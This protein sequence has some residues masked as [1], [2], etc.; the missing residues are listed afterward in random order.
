MKDCVDFGWYLSMNLINLH[1]F[2]LWLHL[3]HREQLNNLP[4]GNASSCS[5]GEAELSVLRSNIALCL[6][7]INFG[8]FGLIFLSSS[9]T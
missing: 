8:S 5:A 7:V 6:A 4:E 2:N 9:S 1:D 3:K